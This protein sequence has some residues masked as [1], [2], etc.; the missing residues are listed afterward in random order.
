MSLIVEITRSVY[1]IAI[2]SLSMM[3][4]MR[5]SIGYIVTHAGNGIISSVNLSMSTKRYSK[6]IIHVNAVSNGEPLF[7]K[8]NSQS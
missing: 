1:Q 8:S 3:N 5:K 6:S 4:L 2:V 7:I